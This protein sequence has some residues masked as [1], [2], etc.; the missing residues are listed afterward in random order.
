MT[1]LSTPTEQLARTAAD[2][3]VS[4]AQLPAGAKAFRIAHL[5]WGAANMAGLGYVYLSA[6][7]RRRDRWLAAYVGLL[8]AEGLALVIGR[9]NCPFGPFQRTLGDPVPMFELFLP[10]RAAKAAIPALTVVTLA[11]FVALVLRR[12]TERRTD[13]PAWQAAPAAA[14]ANWQAKTA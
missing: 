11:G 12:P 4:W 5:V 3:R 6:L 2:P 9:G 1:N 14:P 7:T 8:S 13:R 10:P